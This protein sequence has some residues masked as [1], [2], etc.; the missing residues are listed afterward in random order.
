MVQIEPLTPSLQ[1]KL[2]EWLGLVYTG[3]RRLTK[4]LLGQT[5]RR[6]MARDPAVTAILREIAELARMMRAAF[7]D[8]DLDQFGELIAQRWEINKRMDPESCNPFIDALL[9]R[10]EPCTVG[11]K[12]AGAGGGGF[13][14]VILRDAE[15]GHGLGEI[16]ARHYRRARGA[17]PPRSTSDRAE[18]G[19]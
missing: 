1:R 3:Q 2:T 13:A 6:W 10:C 17:G 12:L 7:L 5:M 19:P 15:A 16:L 11:A 4:D 14:I 18:M 9:R 8:N